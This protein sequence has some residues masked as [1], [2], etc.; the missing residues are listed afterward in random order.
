MYSIMSKYLFEANKKQLRRDEKEEE[1]ER[2]KN[3]EQKMG[4]S[5]IEL[6]NQ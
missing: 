5:A 4:K 3:E 2:M 6:K 1:C